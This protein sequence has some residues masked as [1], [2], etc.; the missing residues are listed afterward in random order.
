ML[1]RPSYNWI[2]NLKSCFFIKYSCSDRSKIS[3]IYVRSKEHREKARKKLWIA[4]NIRNL[5]TVMTEGKKQRRTTQAILL[6]L[7]KV[8]ERRRASRKPGEMK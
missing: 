8:T 3:Q 7:M 6:D 4:V 1:V 2:S 5:A